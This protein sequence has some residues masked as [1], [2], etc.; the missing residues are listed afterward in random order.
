M[1]LVGDH[2]DIRARGQHRKAVLVLARHELLD[3]GKHDAAAGPV[4]Q[5]LAQI[6]ARFGLNRLLAQQ[7]LGQREHAEQ[8]A[9]QV[10]AVGD[11]HDGRVFH[12]RLLHHPRGEAGH[13][14]ALARTLGMP[15]HPALVRTAGARGTYHLADRRTH[16]MELVVASDLLHQPAIILEQHEVAQV[17]QQQLRRQRTAHQ[18]LQLVELAQRIELLAI[19]GAPVHEALGI[20]RQRAHARLAAIGNHQ[21]LVVVEQIGNL[22]LVGLNLIEGLP[23][24]G[25]HIGGVLQ[26][27][28][29]QRQAVDEQDDVRPAGVLGSLHAELVDRQPLVGAHIGPV[30][31]AHEIAAGFAVLLVLHRHPADQQ[32]M[33][34]TISRQLHRHTQLQHLAQRILPRRQRNLRV[35]PSDGRAQTHAQQY[36]AIALALRVI[37]LVGDVRAVQVGVTNLRQPAEGFLFQ[38]VFGHYRSILDPSIPST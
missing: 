18:R 7:I 24:V 27:Q 12:R 36:I 1:R 9:V 20:G 6:T 21:D 31:Q 33:K 34:Q 30:D 29:H 19:D 38:L 5:F 35:E 37:T 15:D 3:G 8:L 28:Q 10:V 13:G 16:G 23:Q 14:D 17:I 32:A 22:L 25:V 11:H 2:H 26:L 4:G